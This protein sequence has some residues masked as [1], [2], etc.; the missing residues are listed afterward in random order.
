MV[1]NNGDPWNMTT[2]LEDQFK[3]LL[4]GF[5]VNILNIDGS[6]ILSLPLLQLLSFLITF[7][8]D[9]R[10]FSWWFLLVDHLLFLIHL[11]KVIW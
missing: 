10:L 6:G 5:V 7:R 8:T 3:F 9:Q 2:V 1:F 4:G 11:I